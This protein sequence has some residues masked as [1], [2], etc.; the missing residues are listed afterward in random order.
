M[1]K[2]DAP[3]RFQSFDANKDGTLTKQEFVQGGTEKK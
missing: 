3:Q 1:G 2:E